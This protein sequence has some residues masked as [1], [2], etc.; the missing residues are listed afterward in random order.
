MV[1][2]DCTFLERRVLTP[3]TDGLR[4]NPMVVRKGRE[5]GEKLELQMKWSLKEQAEEI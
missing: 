4:S 3:E 2:D 1:S 5:F